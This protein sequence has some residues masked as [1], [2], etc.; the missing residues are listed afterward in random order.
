MDQIDDKRDLTTAAKCITIARKRFQLW[1]K[2]QEELTKVTTTRAPQN[3]R[4]FLQKFDDFDRLHVDQNGYGITPAP[5]NIPEKWWKTEEEVDETTTTT[6]PTTTTTTIPTTTTTESRTQFN[7]EIPSKT[8]SQQNPIP[9]KYSTS[10]SDSVQIQSVNSNI[11]PQRSEAKDPFI[12][13]R[14]LFYH[15]AK[16][17][18]QYSTDHSID[19][20]PLKQVKISLNQETSSKSRFKSLSYQL[21]QRYPMYYRPKS[22]S[23]HPYY[24]RWDTSKRFEK[25]RHRVKR[26]L[27]FSDAKK[28]EYKEHFFTVRSQSQFR[29]LK[30]KGDNYS[31]KVSFFSK[32]FNK[33]SFFL[34]YHIFESLLIF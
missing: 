20:K 32:I 24:R 15:K 21:A 16:F 1:S 7:F 9:F 31:G 22:I 14:R 33:F 34:G 29:G 8:A 30:S 3:W 27:R 18:A 5:E 2:K 6:I 11:A 28:H 4:A 26:H 17:P 10:G 12:P 25:L 13:A 23:Y 19:Y